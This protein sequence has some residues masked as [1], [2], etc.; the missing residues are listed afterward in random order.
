MTQNWKS[1]LEIELRHSLLYLLCGLHAAISCSSHLP[2]AE[3]D[4]RVSVWVVDYVY[5]K[6]CGL[7]MDLTLFSALLAI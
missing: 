7:F 6:L 3:F 4:Y 2:V 5:W 1:M